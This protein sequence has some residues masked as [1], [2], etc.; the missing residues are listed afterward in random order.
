MDIFQKWKKGQQL[1]FTCYVKV[2]VFIQK[3]LISALQPS[4]LDKVFRGLV[5]PV[6]VAHHD[7][8]APHVDLALTFIVRVRNPR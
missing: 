1:Q 2:S 5:L 8:P 6:E 3:T 7:V 4:V